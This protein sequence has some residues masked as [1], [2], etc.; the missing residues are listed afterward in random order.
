MPPGVDYRPGHAARSSGAR[1][2]RHVP[3]QHRCTNSLRF[4][5]LAPGRTRFTVTTT[6]GTRRWDV[7]PTYTTVQPNGPRCD[8]ICQFAHVRLMWQ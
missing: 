8:P 1:S 4:G 7:T 2:H 3:G 6:A 5:A